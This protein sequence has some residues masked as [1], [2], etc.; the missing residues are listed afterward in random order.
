MVDKFSWEAPPLTPEDERLVGAYVKLGRSL[1]DLP[2]TEQFNSL[3]A[4]VGLKDTEDN[5]HSVF[6][7]LLRLRKTGRLPR[8][9]MSISA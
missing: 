3:V 7:R 1:D 2:Y 4:M 6:K 9:G 5:K 8:L